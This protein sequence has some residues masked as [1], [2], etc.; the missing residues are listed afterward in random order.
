MM[1]DFADFSWGE[2]PTLPQEVL[3]HHEQDLVPTSSDVIARFLSRG[4][5][6]LTMSQATCCGSVGMTWEKLY[7]YK[8]MNE[9]TLQFFQNLTIPNI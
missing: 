3:P 6:N 8:C 7:V 4:L 5:E 9:Y 1:S 2:I